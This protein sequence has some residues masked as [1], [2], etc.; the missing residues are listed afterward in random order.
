MSVASR[1]QLLAAGAHFGH[2]TELTNSQML[3]YIHSTRGDIHIIDVQKTMAGLDKACAFLRELSSKGGTV[4]FASD[5]R[6]GRAMLKETALRCGMP[7]VNGPWKGGLLTNFNA[8]QR[9]AEK[10]E[11]M[12]AL[13]SAAEQGSMS[14]DEYVQMLGQLAKLEKHYAGLQGMKSLPDALFT[15]D[16]WRDHTAIR[17]ARACHIPVISIVDTNCSP[18]GVDFVIPGNDDA[19]KFLRLCG[20][21]MSAAI[22]GK[23]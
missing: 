6:K 18:D 20:E 5:K 7:Y 9:Q 15:I 3:P 10:L 21:L 17:E 12:R 14:R 8:F 22:L 2:K 23:S 11:E 1:S 16:T 19:I 4:L 13:R